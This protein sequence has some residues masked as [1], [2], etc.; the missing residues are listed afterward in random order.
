MGTAIL[1]VPESLHVAV[2]PTHSCSQS[3]SKLIKPDITLYIIKPWFNSAK[4]SCLVEY[5]SH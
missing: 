2:A 4:A 5:R 1:F 3:L